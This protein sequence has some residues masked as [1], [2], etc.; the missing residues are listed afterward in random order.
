MSASSIRISRNLCVSCSA[1]K[2]LQKALLHETCRFE[3]LIT[4]T[5]EVKPTSD[6]KVSKRPSSISK[7]PIIV[8]RSFGRGRSNLISSTINSIAFFLF[9][10]ETSVVHFLFM[11]FASGNFNF[12]KI[13]NCSLP[14]GRRSTSQTFFILTM[15][16]FIHF[17][18]VLS[19]VAASSKDALRNQILKGDA[20]GVDP[21]S[22]LSESQLSSDWSQHVGDGLVARQDHVIQTFEEGIYIEVSPYFYISPEISHC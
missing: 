18:F 8:M 19:L 10:F 3:C 2:N 14:L 9:S 5:I 12:W 13:W 20:A 15:I 16:T 6:W 4:D 21:F 7:W 1:P 17:L 22:I 11:M